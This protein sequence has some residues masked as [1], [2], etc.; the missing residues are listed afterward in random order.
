MKG[1]IHDSH[2][3]GYEADEYHIGEHNTQERQYGG[4]FG[5]LVGMVDCKGDDC[6]SGEGNR[7]KQGCQ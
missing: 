6:D 7:D 4:G 1:C 3:E 2:A 5:S